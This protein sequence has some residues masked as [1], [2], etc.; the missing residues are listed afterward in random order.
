MLPS[1]V[2]KVMFCWKNEPQ[3]ETTSL[4]RHQSRRKIGQ[5]A[6]AQKTSCSQFASLRTKKKHNLLLCALLCAFAGCSIVMWTNGN[7]KEVGLGKN[8]RNQGKNLTSFLAFAQIKRLRNQAK[9]HSS[10]KHIFLRIVTSRTLVVAVVVVALRLLT[11]FFAT[12]K[13]RYECIRVLRYACATIEVLRCVFF[14][15][16]K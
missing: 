12:Q 16:G 6:R 2:I 13:Q 5:P 8:S 14:F 1:A 9:T 15:F 11:P 10:S 7:R 3:K 4:L